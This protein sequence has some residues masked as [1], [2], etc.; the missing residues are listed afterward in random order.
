MKSLG[1]LIATAAIALG[2][3]ALAAAPTCAQQP[4][5][6]RPVLGGEF[7]APAHVVY[8]SFCSIPAAPT[9]V[10]TAEAFKGQVVRTRL[11][12]AVVTRDTA[13]EAWTLAGTEDFLAAGRSEAAPPPPPAAVGPNETAAFIAAAKAAAAPPPKPRHRR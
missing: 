4:P 7:A 8:P 3:P 12:G 13:P 2:G 6:A 10:P 9:N 1:L 5:P 11:A